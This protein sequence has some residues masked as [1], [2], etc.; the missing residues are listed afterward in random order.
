VCLI[1]LGRREGIDAPVGIYLKPRT[2]VV[3]G[4]YRRARVTDRGE[5]I[6]VAQMV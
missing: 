1:K 2:A 3:L 4:V 5:R 6:G